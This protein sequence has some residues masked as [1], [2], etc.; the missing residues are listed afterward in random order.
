MANSIEPAESILSNAA[1]NPDENELNVEDYLTLHLYP[2]L[3][4]SLALLDKLRPADPIDF[5]ALELFRRAKE[6]QVNKKELEDLYTVKQQ[7]RAEIAAE[8]AVL[9]RV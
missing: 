8:Q 1:T 7:L 4:S 2:S 5:L 9:G 6:S 3:N